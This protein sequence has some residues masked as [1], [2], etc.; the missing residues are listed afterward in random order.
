MDRKPRVFIGSSS[1]A[2]TFAQHFYTVLSERDF[3]PVSWHY[4][5]EAGKS[6][7][8]GL[9]EADPF[10][11]AVLLIT[12]DDKSVSRGETRP[13]PR[14]N[15]WFEAGFFI[16]RLGPERVFLLV[17]KSVRHDI[18]IPSDLAGIRM[19][20]YDDQRNLTEL[21]NSFIPAVNELWTRY[22]AIGLAKSSM[23]DHNPSRPSTSSS[24]KREIS[25]SHRAQSSQTEGF[26]AA[27]LHEAI[28]A[29]LA[30][31]DFPIAIVVGGSAKYDD[32]R[33][34]AWGMKEYQST[35]PVTGVVTLRN[36]TE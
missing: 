29:I 14:D 23:V 21:T 6:Y 36:S 25:A 8:S 2:S 20:Y 5:F 27:T 1:E 11:F 33:R 24:S 35:Q 32:D 9:V 12:A 28:A 10:D 26:S 3:E 13:A 31:D 16:G 7:L 17:A 4:G 18:K 19:L 15:I 34:L 30:D 22:L